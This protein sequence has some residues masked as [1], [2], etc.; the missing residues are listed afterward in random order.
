MDAIS[1]GSRNVSILLNRKLSIPPVPIKTVK[2]NDNNMNAAVETPMYQAV[3]PINKVN[4][5]EVWKVFLEENEDELD[6][7][8]VIISSECILNGYRNA[9]WENVKYEGFYTTIEEAQN[10]IKGYIR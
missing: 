1:Q 9:E 2:K 4:V 6:F 5:Y 3:E 7:V 10:E 8:F